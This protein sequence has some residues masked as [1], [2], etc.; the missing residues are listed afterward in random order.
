MR[1]MMV[2]NYSQNAFYKMNN[3]SGD[4]KSQEQKDTSFKGGIGDWIGKTYGK[5]Y[6][7]PM[8]NKTWVRG[9]AKTI[10]RAP[11]STTE[12]MSVLG[13]LFTSG[14]YMHKTLT[15]ENFNDKRKKTLALNQGLC[16]LVPTAGAYYVNS[17]LSDLNKKYE[18]RYS[19]LQE[20]KKA[21]GK[22][23]PEQIKEMEKNL[24]RRLSGFKTLA[25][26]LTFTLIYRYATPVL[27]TPLANWIGRKIN[28][29][30]A[31]KD[32]KENVAQN[33]NSSDDKK[34]KTAA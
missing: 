11:G 3:D 14:V 31:P 26:L 23:T 15:N 32:Q 5:Y 21:M 33:E 18:Y 30:D 10:A 27:V 1:T 25:S 12:H 24:G 34:I 16:F 13:S 28:G 19:G 4:I 29:E 7:E 22:L 2:N 17:K 20:Q 6:A 8:Y 9:M